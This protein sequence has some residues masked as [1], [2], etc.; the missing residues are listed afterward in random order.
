MITGLH[1]LTALLALTMLAACHPTTESLESIVAK[2]SEATGGAAAIESV[3][4][5]QFKLHITDPGFEVDGE[6][7]AMRPGRMRIDVAAGG[8][9]VFT[10]AFNGRRAW[11]WKG[12]G[13]IVEE[14]AQATAALKHGVELPGKVFG[15]HELP[16]HGY[17]LSLLPSETI[18]GT[19]YRVIQVTTSDGYKTSLYIDPNTWLITRKREFRPLHVDID[20]RPSTIETL[21]SDF[22]EVNGVK[23][24]FA[25]T[26]TDLQTGKLLETTRVNEIV[27]NPKIDPTIFDQ[28]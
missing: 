9:Q 2:N 3:Q 14:S 19:N 4:S 27:I 10:E 13:E 7:R 22:R 11:Q 15:L 23:F 6:Y 17:E 26:E 1:R 12:K 21:F 16:A 20:P 24:A 28:L 25:S 5:I 8:K 18:G